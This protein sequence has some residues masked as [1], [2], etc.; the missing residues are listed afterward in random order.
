V[1][2]WK[3]IYFFSLLAFVLIFNVSSIVF[4]ERIHNKMLEQEITSTLSENLNIQ[5]S[6]KAIVPIMEIYDSPDYEKKVMEQI[7]NEFISQNRNQQMFI[8]IHD[9]DNKLI[10]SNAN[11]KLPEERE[12]LDGLQSQEI[13]YILRDIG[14]RTLL[15][16]ANLIDVQNK[17][18]LFTYTK[19]VTPLYEEK[20]DQYRFFMQMDIIACLLYMLIMF[21]VSKGL[22]RPIEKLIQS[23]KVITQGDFTERV[24]L[25][26][27]DEVG[28]LSGH[29]NRMADTVENTIKELE[30]HNSE[31]DRFIQNFTHEIK[32]PLTS[33]I[34]YAN[35]LRVTKYNEEALVDGLN[36][37]SSEAK[38]LESLSFKL[39]DLILLRDDYFE[40]ETGDLKKVIDDIT[41][42]LKIKAMPKG[43]E[44]VTECESCKLELETDLIKLLLT[45]LV[46]NAIQASPEH[47]AI[48]IK[49]FNKQEKIHLEVIDQ[50][51]GIPEKHL[52]NIFEPFYMVDKARTRKHNGAGLGLSIC[53]SVASLHHAIIEAESEAGR[54][55]TLRVIFDSHRQRKEEQQ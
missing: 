46:D 49:A 32:T 7:V 53:Q 27:R 21:V 5:A 8:E 4:I 6:V 10:F 24:K 36:V 35:Y 26:T 44:I 15:F 23:V 55:S 40:M 33:I 39:M 12:E 3:K 19:D 25:K 50:G 42:S 48:M 34:G 43:M 41:P 16:T 38:R 9:E 45:N 52:G 37:I 11:Q 29:F 28:V 22:T 2:F 20:M 17:A 51:T 18:Y 30:L 1:K 13:R 31:K 54:G 47:S 14:E